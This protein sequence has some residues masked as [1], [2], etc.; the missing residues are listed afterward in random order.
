M[1]N[2]LLLILT[3][4]LFLSLVLTVVLI[5]LLPPFFA[6][7][8]IDLLKKEKSIQ[9][10]SIHYC[11]LN[12]D[13][14][15]EEINILKG[16]ENRTLI[17][18]REKGVIVDQWSFK[19]TLTMTNLFFGDFNNDG[20]KEVYILT[21]YQNKILLNSFS[22]LENKR[23]IIDK[24]VDPFYP[25]N[26]E[27]TSGLRYCNLIDMDYDGFKELIFAFSAGFSKAPRR[28]YSYNIAN[29]TLYKSPKSCSVVEKVK[30]V[31][32]EEDQK[33]F[34]AVSTAAV[35][36]CDSL[37][38]L[39][40]RHTWLKVI[41]KKLQFIFD[42][43][44]IGYYPSA[45]SVLPIKINNEF[46]LGALN[47]YFGNEKHPCSITLY[48]LEGKKI[49][50][51]NF[52]YTDEWSSARLIN[53]GDDYDNIFIFKENGLIEEIDEN[54]NF[55]KK[56]K[57]FEINNNKPQMLDID[58][59]DEEEFV[60]HN[61][62]KEKI[63]ILRNDFSDPILI[64]VPG[65]NGLHYSSV[66]L[67]GKEKP[68][69]FL[70]FDQYSYYYNYYKNPLYNFQY[71]FYALIYLGIFIIVFL[72]QKA[73]KYR[74]EH[75][76]KAEKKI[77]ELQIKSIKNQT[78]P[79]FTLNIINSIGSLFA[80]QDTEKA[81]YV[82]GKYSKLLRSTILSSDQILT[83]LDDEIEYVENYL[84][85]EQFRFKDG[86]DF[87]VDIEENI[88]GETKIPKMLIHTFVENSLKHGI[89]HL[90][91][92]G[93]LVISVSN[94]TNTYQIKIKD[95]GIGRTKAKEINSF[96]TGKGLEIMNQILD[97]YYTLEKVKINYNFEDLRS[98]DDESEG[99]EVLIKIP[100]F[101][102]K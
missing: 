30:F 82:F 40:D 76:Y 6:K 45:L 99:T 94:D 66:V 56:Q 37:A 20:F 51:K 41:D 18:V 15:S 22:P 98:K 50:E 1:K 21:I 34:F 79:H 27:R 57:V 65:N 67:N 71:L 72:L 29:D 69:L 97:L 58:L 26:G 80:K 25:K 88:N 31:K 101:N 49:K 52:P 38:N 100:I 36:N 7:Y 55:I 16:F 23:Y 43:I 96:G 47:I 44:K 17:I 8:K 54:L 75:K 74:V 10:N 78:D 48:D 11:D 24:E 102:L 39:T 32:S 2:K 77:A 90:K 91:E 46:Y 92:R 28:I 83:T 14:Y 59:D 3:N 35:G 53:K 64:D 70:R 42:P 86:F 63:T 73:E 89:K 93:K 9:S 33:S 95:N 12:S 62:G 84:S 68:Q 85:L 4:P 60:F 87:N 61:D 13:G 81:N 19:G 5:I